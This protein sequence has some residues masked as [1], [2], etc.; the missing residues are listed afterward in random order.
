[1]TVC[2]VFSVMLNYILIRFLGWN[3]AIVA[4]NVSFILAG[5][6]LLIVGEKKFPIP[7]EWRR[8]GIAVGLFLAIII[9][10]LAL[11]AV[12]N[13]NYYWISI[14]TICVMGCIFHFG[15]FYNEQEKLLLRNMGE[16][17]K[18]IFTWIS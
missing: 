17:V 2:A 12:N 5:S 9:L 10:N 1:M 13:S 8:L 14:I 15:S 16:K 3:G 7:I 11:L 6:T 18:T 4:T